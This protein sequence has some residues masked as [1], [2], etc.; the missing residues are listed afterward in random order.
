MT[1]PESLPRK[2]LIWIPLGFSAAY[3]VGSCAVGFYRALGAGA[4]ECP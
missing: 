1:Q 3:L 4:R 2:N